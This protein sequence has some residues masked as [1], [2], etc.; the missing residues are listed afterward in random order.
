MNT[1][2]SEKSKNDILSNLC[3]AHKTEVLG[4]INYVSKT[5]INKLFSTFESITQETKLIENS[6]KSQSVSHE[7]DE[8]DSIE[9]A[10]FAAVDHYLVQNNMK[11]EFL[12]SSFVWIF[13]LFEKDCAQIFSIRN[14][15]KK[16]EFLEYIGVDV[17]EDSLWKK[18]NNELRNIANVAKHGDNSL[19][20]LEKTRPD[21]LNEE[22]LQVSIEIFNHYV[23]NMVDFWD[24][25][26]SKANAFKEENRIP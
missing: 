11:K 13:H 26:F 7:T 12:N 20:Q 18:C 15:E 4:K 2:L 16:K 22:E 23:Q 8:Y 5:I 3:E 25:F 1:K 10:Y 19:K 17:S 24:H 9:K 14:G 21:L 6:Y